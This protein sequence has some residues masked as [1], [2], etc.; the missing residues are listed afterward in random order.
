M[1][2]FAKM[3]TRLT[4]SAI[5]GPN[6]GMIPHHLQKRALLLFAKSYFFIY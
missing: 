6:Q 2:G 5:G 3:L 4:A 1:A